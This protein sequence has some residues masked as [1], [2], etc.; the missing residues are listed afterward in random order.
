[1]ISCVALCTKFHVAFALFALFAGCTRWDKRGDGKRGGTNG[2]GIDSGDGDDARRREI[3]VQ[4]DRGTNGHCNA[5]RRTRLALV[6]PRNFERKFFLLNLQL[7]HA[8][9]TL[10][11]ILI[12]NA[13]RFKSNSTT[14][15]ASRLRS[16]SGERKKKLYIYTIRVSYEPSLRVMADVQ[17][18]LPL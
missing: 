8:Q 15:A 2:L 7:F 16:A 4:A 18:K 10:E 13:V 17:C 12:L 3:L 9:S 6:F 5:D 1:M 14:Q 11:H